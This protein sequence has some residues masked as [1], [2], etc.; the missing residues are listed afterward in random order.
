MIVTAAR[1]SSRILG[2]QL[3]FSLGV[4]GILPFAVPFLL[5]LGRSERPPTA[6]ALAL[7]LA[8]ATTVGLVRN[9]LVLR[10]QRF[11]L[12]GLALGART[13]E[14]FEAQE[15]EREPGRVIRGWLAP[16]IVGLAILAW[17]LRPALLDG[18]TGLSLAL[19]GS[20]IVAAAA[21]PLY[22]LV[23]QVIVAA[24]E[25][26]P[27]EV[28]REVV[29]QEERTGRTRGRV[30]WRLLTACATPVA[31]VAIGAALIVNSHLR[32]ADERHRE[33]T[34]RALARTALE[35][36]PGVVADAGRAEA[37]A[38]A[39]GLGFSASV[40]SDPAASYRVAR[41]ADGVV[42]LTTPLD[43]GSAR[44]RFSGSTVSVL[45]ATSLLITLFGVASA[46][47]FG[48]WLGRML[49]RDLEAATRG[50]RLLGTEAVLSGGTRVMRPTR[51]EVIANLGSAVELLAD[52]FRLF[53]RAQERA[54]VAREAAA[55]MRGLFLAS[56]SHDL[57]SPLNAV[58]GFT[59]L[60]RNEPLGDGQLESLDV[61]ER[62]G[63]ELLALIETILDAARVGAG[64]LDI[65]SERCTVR[66]LLELAIEKGCDLA[67]DHVM[68]V[69]TELAEGLPALEVDEVRTARALASLVGRSMRMAEA[70]PLV[71]RAAPSGSA[72]RIDVVVN[73]S[74]FHAHH[75]EALL[76]PGNSPGVTAKYR[77]LALGL[78][79][80]R[81]IIRMHGGS[82]HAEAVGSSVRA[83]RVTLP[84]GRQP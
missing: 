44:V 39:R 2:W 35:T 56:V 12:R 34:A 58:L 72:V 17:P 55:R 3:L 7:C 83:F 28:I 71:I 81:T 80:A 84:A 31:F 1:A 4:T 57:K 60:V 61:I 19:L 79:L 70:G 14:P 38:S 77:G 5:L 26:A 24:L 82:V 62:R 64:Q 13:L 43:R 67:G 54:I 45:S 9:W 66:E 16:P 15:L 52:R 49:S 8:L 68:Q 23:R 42:L 78:S 20:V 75:L 32:R 47:A 27:A 36:G 46:G 59:Q 21:L 76:D 11:V 29:E 74:R 63:R 22:V 65:V 53:A 10:R 33:E 30:A 37:M 6:R 25:L 50:I 73:T 69:R 41:G 51:F 40:S 48:L 18:T